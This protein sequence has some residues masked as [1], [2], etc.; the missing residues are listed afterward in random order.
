MS[1]FFNQIFNLLSSP[2]G[3]LI[4]HVVLIFSIGGTLQGAI[5]LLQSSAFPQVRRT[6]YGLIVLLGLQI[7]PFILSA[8]PWHGSVGAGMLLPPTD[9]AITMIG[10]VWIAWLWVF[11]EPLRLA[12]F[13]T[14]LL[15]GLAII[16]FLVTL[17]LGVKNPPASYN[18]SAFEKIWQ[19]L[20]LLVAILGMAGLV[21]RKTNG[22]GNGIAMLFLALIGHIVTLVFPVQGDFPGF[23]RLT[24]L[25]MFP[26]LLTLVQRYPTPGIPRTP[27]ATVE[28]STEERRVERRR[29]STDPKTLSALLTLAGEENADKVG[30]ALVHS[31]AQALLT[32]LCF[33]ITI[34]DDKNLIINCGYD[35]IRE[36]TLEGTT[37]NKES[38]PLLASAILR[39]RPLRLPAS[40]TSADMKGLG[41][42]LS[43]TDPGNLLSVPILSRDQSPLGG[44]LILS[45]YSSRLWTADDQAYLVNASPLF[46]PILERAQRTS[47]L[48]IERNLA[49]QDMASAKEQ[50][51]DARQKY[52]QASKELEGL[53][54]KVNGSQLQAENTAALLIM[55]DENQKTIHSLKAEIER[56]TQSGNLPGAPIPAEGLQPSM[57]QPLEEFTS[58]N[59]GAGELTTGPLELKE[60]PSGPITTEQV[61]VISSISQE[62]RQPMSSIVGYTDLLMGESVGGLSALQRKFIERIKA[63]TEKIGSLVD[64]LVQ[65]TS[66]ETGKMQFRQEPIDLNL[67][68][69]NAMAYTSTQIREKNITLRLD[70][71]DTSPPIQTDRDAFQQILIHL[72]QNATGATQAEGV[73]TLRVQTQREGEQ[74][75]LA[76]QVAD[77][78]G[79]ISAEDLPRVFERR[80][81]AEN[82]QIQ[83]LGDTGVGLSIAKAL[84]EAQG[85]RIWVDSETGNGSTF[86]IQLPVLIRIEEEK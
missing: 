60:N 36:E 5:H 45:P 19:V 84:V 7:V 40:S 6:V 63:S 83:G 25:A 22:W 51:E 2:S 3:N 76:V 62:L 34:T 10:L 82:S 77:T 1:L 24:Q 78:G 35:L 38:V 58:V 12:D 27:T 14:I 13:G 29:Y 72:L 16:I 53:H 68:I 79:G 86:N 46:I 71:P 9:R 64:N 26:I 81:K 73:I 85:G 80:Y 44:L 56:L 52:D 4:Y 74:N 31:I 37:V 23:V 43:L 15:S 49:R 50:A 33:L 65:I 70:I 11:P 69:D 61:E 20:S 41:E 66:L 48:E 39:G 47:K 42:L 59:A 57:Q 17:S 8:I 55:Q 18:L 54:E 21:L 67:I 75:Y 32:D 30:I 28:K